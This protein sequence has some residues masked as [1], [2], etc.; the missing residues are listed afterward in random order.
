VSD[1]RDKAGRYRQRNGLDILEEYGAF[2]M[3]AL[4]M[5]SFLWVKPCFQMLVEVI[6]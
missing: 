6:G 1:Y 5:T 2:V 4:V 3:I